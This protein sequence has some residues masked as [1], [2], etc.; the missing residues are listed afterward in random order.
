MI[1]ERTLVHSVSGLE[2]R[3]GASAIQSIPSCQP[4]ASARLSFSFRSGR[5]S[6]L[7]TPKAS[8]P[9]D[10]ARLRSVVARSEIKIRISR[11]GGHTTDPVGEQ[12]TERR[13]RLD[14]GVP[15][16]GFD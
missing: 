4:R 12:R 3:S 2:R 6:G 7:V 11:V 8:K 14:A 16:A 13:T 9:R 10:F 1:T 15:M 5:A